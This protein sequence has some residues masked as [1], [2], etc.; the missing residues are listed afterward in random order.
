MTDELVARGVA[1]VAQGKLEYLARWP[2][3][4]GLAKDYVRRGQERLIAEPLL[5]Q[6]VAQCGGQCATEQRTHAVRGGYLDLRGRARE[7]AS[8]L[9][10]FAKRR[11]R[12]RTLDR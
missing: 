10:S 4:K 1:E 12:D 9:S 7:H 2:L 6:L 3:V 5:E 11:R 8:I